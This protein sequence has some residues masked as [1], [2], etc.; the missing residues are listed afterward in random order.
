MNNTLLIFSE[1]REKVSVYENMLSSAGYD[2]VTIAPNA[3]IE[4]SLADR[5]FLI[6]VPDCT[7]DPTPTIA[8][9]PLPGFL[10]VLVLGDTVD[11][12]DFLATKEISRLIDY[13]GGKLQERALLVRIDFLKKVAKLGH[14]RDSYLQHHE[15]FLDWFSLRDGLTGLF[16]RHHFNRLLPK[17]FV[18][19][20]TDNSDL[21]LLLI[22]IDYFHDI[23]ATCGRSFGDFV[24]NELG[25]RITQTTRKD[26][27]CFRLSGGEFAV[28]MPGINLAGARETAN[29]LLACCENKP[30]IRKTLQ[31]TATLSI[32]IASLTTHR[33][34]SVD[35]FV[36][37]TDTALFKAKAEG[38]NRAYVYAPLEAGGISPVEGS[39]DNV[40]LA[41]NRLL[42]KTRN[43]TIS[44]LQLLARDIAGPSHREHLERVTEYIDLLCGRLGLTAPI[45][46]T[47]QNAAVLHTSIRH[48]IH[49]DLLIKKE[50]FSVEDLEVMRDF[51]Y[52]LSEIVDIFDYFAQE[53]LV[54]LTRTEK[55][56]G[57]GYPDGLRGDEIPLGARIISIIDAFAAM[58]ANRPYRPRLSPETILLELKNEAGKQFDPFL[59]LKLLDIIEEHDLLE[60]SADDLATIRTELHSTLANM[61]L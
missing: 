54:L 28:L 36:N 47:L 20:M 29:E 37:M 43:S 19:A 17:H 23:N 42:D 27:V 55:F 9:L 14:E 40:K 18:G 10:P 41:I 35:E 1:D 57:S 45:I 24:L 13:L 59:V 46:K 30:F 60:I 58:E 3:T 5:I 22:D 7:S 16:N 53:R 31:R 61:K 32:G 38:R 12:P 50:K 49:N 4:P 44:S 39:F 34:T 52:K 15:N 11:P 26:D 2:T 21:S 25:A 33:P 6:L 48:L 8:K 51:P 56:D